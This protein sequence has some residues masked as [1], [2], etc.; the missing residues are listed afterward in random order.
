MI[1]NYA[2]NLKNQSL[3]IY[4]YGFD[5]FF[6]MTSLTEESIY[7]DTLTNYDTNFMWCSGDSIWSFIY[8]RAE[9][10]A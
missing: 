6:L 4:S 1:R 7:T 3:G 9:A 8:L 2:I 10:A 5:I